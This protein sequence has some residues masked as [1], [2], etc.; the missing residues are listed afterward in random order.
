MRKTLMIVCGLV[1]LA[2]A[3]PAAA[4]GTAAGGTTVLVGEQ[5]RPPAGVPKS[6][7][8]NLFFP[9]KVVVRAGS[10]V[11]FTSRG[12]HTV[13]FVKG[14]T[15]P[16]FV[17]DPSG[18]VYEGIVD[19]AGEEFGFNSLTALV[20]NVGAF[21]PSGGTTIDG[22]KT[23]SSGVIVPGQNG[24]PVSVTYLFPKPGTYKLVCL[25]HPGMS[26][27][28][29]V[30]PKTATVPGN[31]QV[32][33][34]AKRQ[35]D[36]AWNKALAASKTKVPKNTVYTGIGAQAT[37]LAFLPEKLK[38]KVGTT[39]RFASGTTSEPHNVAL[40]PQKWFDAF[41]KAHDLF[42]QGPKGKNQAS[43]FFAYGSDPGQTLVYDGSNHGNGVLVTPLTAKA[44]PLPRAA[45]VTF[46]KAGTYKYFCLLHGPD[47]SGTIVVTK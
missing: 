45:S 35:L 19:A 14:K 32:A 8:L 9:G 7:T 21:A 36:T 42:P 22:R 31:E 33:A 6:A 20:Y 23:V 15:P 28:V 29:V 25:I 47:M 12:F 3:G 24:K 17:P 30:K 18:A 2:V 46:A 27:L 41:Q 26:T 16:I 1:A 11:T 38:V 37:L 13:S 39:V 43:P 40:G 10:K 44:G 5:D 4:H 34:A